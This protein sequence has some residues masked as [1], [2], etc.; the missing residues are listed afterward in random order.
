MGCLGRKRPTTLDREIAMIRWFAILIP[1]LFFTPASAHDW[2]PWE[3][4]SGFDR[5]PVEKV[6]THDLDLI[7]SS[8]L[9]S[10][11]VPAS[12]PRRESKDKRMHVCMRQEEG[13][14]KLNCIFMPPPG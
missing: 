5:A 9:G 11:T 6:N 7:V 3:C 12:F 13:R 14:M 2:Y 1:F 4:C 10:V 8:K